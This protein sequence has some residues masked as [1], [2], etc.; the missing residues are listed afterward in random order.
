M[1]EAILSHNPTIPLS[2]VGLPDGED[3]PHAEN[4]R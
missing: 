4:G 3:Y 2:S 1:E